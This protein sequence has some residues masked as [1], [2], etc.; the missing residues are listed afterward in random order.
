MCRFNEVEATFHSVNN[1]S[2]CRFNE[3]E[4]TS[5]VPSLNLFR[6]FKKKAKKT[7][8][9]QIIIVSLRLEKRNDYGSYIL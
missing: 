4:T 5:Q 3:V 8:Y 7:M 9:Y 2:M 1:Q 6:A